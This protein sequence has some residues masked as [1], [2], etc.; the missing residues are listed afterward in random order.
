M[1]SSSK[2]KPR[3]DPIAVDLRQV[4]FAIEGLP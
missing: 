3:L 2:G 4:E 1:R